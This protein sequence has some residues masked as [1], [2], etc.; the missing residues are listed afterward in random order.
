MTRTGLDA[1]TAARAL[2]LVNLRESRFGVH[3]DRIKRTRYFTVSM[4]EAPGGAPAL[5]GKGRVS[6]DTAGGTIVGHLG[7][8]ELAASTATKNGYSLFGAA[9]L[10]PKILADRCHRFAAAGGAVEVRDITGI[11]AFHEGRRHSGTAGK[12][13]GTAVD[14]REHLC[15]FCYPR[16]L[17]NREFLRDYVQDRCEDRGNRAKREHRVKNG[18]NHYAPSF[19]RG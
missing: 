15:D 16:I 1:G 8:R 5:T 4:A 6:E 10:E 2:L 19:A 14:T 13:A 7:R 9:D 17:M 3:R 11:G 18:L 12:T